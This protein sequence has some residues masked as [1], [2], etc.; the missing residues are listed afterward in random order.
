MVTAKKSEAEIVDHYV[1]RYGERILREPRGLRSLWLM[2][3]PLAALVVGGTALTVYL[4]HASRA[5]PAEAGGE[6][7]AAAMPKWDEDE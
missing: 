2:I 7:V 6:A 1:A 3:V 5:A 4:R